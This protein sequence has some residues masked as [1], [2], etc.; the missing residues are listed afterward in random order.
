[1]LSRKQQKARESHK[2]NSFRVGRVSSG[3][4]CCVCETVVGK[5]EFF[6]NKQCGNCYESLFYYLYV[7][8]F[9]FVEHDESFRDIYFPNPFLPKPKHK[10]S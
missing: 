5:D 2:K 10:T 3:Q 6:R 4:K 9:F 8:M 7:N 1:M